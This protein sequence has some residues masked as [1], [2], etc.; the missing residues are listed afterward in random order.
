MLEIPPGATR[1]VL[2]NILLAFLEV[3]NGSFSVQTV[4]HVRQRTR[5]CVLVLSRKRS[6][7]GGPARTKPQTSSLPP[8]SVREAKRAALLWKLTCLDRF[9]HDFPRYGS[10][11]GV[12]ISA[13]PPSGHVFRGRL[14]SL[15]HSQE[16][17]SPARAPERSYRQATWMSL[18]LN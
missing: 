10:S 17:D 12:Q 5:V 8:A 9:Q 6:A 2:S 18:L 13:F 14:S 16:A 3:L 4:Q 1:R 11:P 7:A 15:P